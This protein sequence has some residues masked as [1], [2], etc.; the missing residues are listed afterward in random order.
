[1]LYRV[2]LDLCFDG[3]ALADGVYEKAKTILSKAINIAHPGEIGSEVSYIEVHKCYHDETP[4]KPC[5]IIKRI[6]V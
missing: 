1:M 6:E 5:E 4:T 3:E 2:R